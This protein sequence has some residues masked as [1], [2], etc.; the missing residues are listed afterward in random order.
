MEVSVSLYCVYSI[1]EVVSFPG[2][3]GGI[4]LLRHHFSFNLKI[5]ILP[6]YRDLFAIKLIQGQHHRKS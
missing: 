4:K 6:N 5:S 1:T 2:G 3:G